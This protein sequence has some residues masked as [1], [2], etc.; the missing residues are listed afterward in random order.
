MKPQK[1]QTLNLF[2]LQSFEDAAAYATR[3]FQ[4]AG[5]IILARNLQH[6]SA[7]IFTQEFPDLTFLQQGITINNEGGY[8]S[9]IQKLKLQIAGGFRESGSNTNT[10]GKITLV[11][12]QDNIPV[13]SKEAE[14][15]WS[16]VELKQAELQ[17]ISLPGRMLE[18]H[19]EVYNRDIDQIGYLGQV[20][21]NGSQK[22]TGLLNYAG[23]DTA[24]A[25]GPAS[26]MSGLDLYNAIAG[27]I[28]RQWALVYNT[29]AY[30]A[31]RV[32]MPD[33]VYNTASRLILNSAGSEM[34]VLRA[35]QTN[36]PE[37]TFG[38]TNVARS[39]GG[40]SKTIAFSDNRRAMQFR[41]PVPLNIS[42]IHQKGWKYYVESYFGVAGLDVIENGAAAVLTGL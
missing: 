7:E 41:L 16:E 9:S 26:G 23:W 3:H 4:D 11:G 1:K 25:A 42:S 12:E 38:L 29:A 39:V 30:R 15:D 20:R 36:F 27:L 17:G 32:I 33:N 21:T 8:A 19:V 18:A 10:N 31:N 40:S 2:K 34:S 35:L 13:Y 22:T 5:G 28:N 37:I 24:A 6:L 14:S